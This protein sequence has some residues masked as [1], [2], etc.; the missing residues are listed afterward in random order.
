VLRADT[1]TVVGDV[2]ISEGVMLTIEPGAGLRFESNDALSSGVDPDKVELIVAG[3]LV[4]DGVTFTSDA[5]SP[6]AGD[7]YGIRFLDGSADWDGSGGS[8]IRNSIIEYGTVGVSTEGASPLIATNTIRYM[9]GRD[10]DSSNVMDPNECPEVNGGSGYGIHISGEASP[11]IID[12]I[13]VDIRGGIGGVC[14]FYP[15]GRRYGKGGDAV[16]IFSGAKSSPRIVNNVISIIDAGAPGGLGAGVY[17]GGSSANIYQNQISLATGGGGASAGYDGGIGAGVYILDGSSVTIDSNMISSISG[18]IGADGWV[19]GL[20]RVGRRTGDGG[21]GAGIYATNSSSLDIANNLIS[22]ITGGK[23]GRGNPECY[24]APPDPGGRGANGV[25][26]HV[27]NS[28]LLNITNN[29]ISELQG[30]DG[31]DG[32]PAANP[33]EYPPSSGGV[34]GSGVGIYAE[35][36]SAM[37]MNN[38]VASSAGGQGGAPGDPNGLL[39]RQVGDSTDDAQEFANGVYDD[40]G[41]AMLLGDDNGIQNYVGFR[42][43]GVW[44]TKEAVIDS[45]VLTLTAYESKSATT[46]FLIKGEAIGDSPTF[47]VDNSPRDRMPTAASVAWTVTEDWEQGQTYSSPDLSEV[48][49]EIVNRKDWRLGSALT[50]LVLDVEPDNRNRTVSTWDKDYR[51]AAELAIAWHWPKEVSGTRGED[52]IGVGVNLD[53]ASTMTITNNIVVSHTIGISGT[54]NTATLS[55]NDVWGNSEA[56]YSGV[57]PGSNDI[58]AD[59]PSLIRPTTTIT[60]SAAHRPL[61]R[62]LT[63]VPRPPTSR[64]IYV[65]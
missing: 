37:L 51:E 10:G 13:I 18:G 30:G 34:G 49:Q 14:R 17:L 41:S 47:S 43:S 19:G 35:A 33:E 31:G 8:V 28:S 56:N 15:Y 64:V 59:P 2:T 5:G 46:Q 32:V 50:I 45:T 48:I 60:C 58:S 6:A 54:A 40:S 21:I 25:G 4:A 57:A 44:V 65:L 38:T 16:A 24:D 23:G 36:S 52:G 12:N 55:Y 39:V 3:T 61:M 27:V 63:R 9:K 29:I 62:V 7:W 26:I 20:C 11:E 22:E 1:Y 53:A 42:F